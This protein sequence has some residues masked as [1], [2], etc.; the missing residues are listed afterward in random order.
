MEQ[1]RNNKRG[2]IESPPATIRTPKRQNVDRARPAHSKACSR[3][4]KRKI[5]CDYVLPSCSSCKAAGALC[6]G[7]DLALQKEVPRSIV[8]YLE[9]RAAA[10]EIE[11][12]RLEASKLSQCA[13]Q[14]GNQPIANAGN[15]PTPLS[16][17]EALAAAMVTVVTPSGVNDD[18]TRFFHSAF[19]LRPCSLPLP[20]PNQLFRSPS[21]DPVAPS[22]SSRKATHLPDVPRSAADLVLKN[23]VEIHLPQY[24]CVYE[25]DLLRAYELCFDRP[26]EASPFDVFIVCMALAISANTLIWRNEENARAAS[27][28]FWAN[29]M[30]QLHNPTT[31][32]SDIKKL[33]SALL[34][35]HYSFTNPTAVDV[36]YCVGDAARL[37]IQLGYH[38]EV[39]LSSNLNTLELDTRRRLFWTTYGME[40]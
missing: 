15:S 8:S 22:R 3:C 16:I 38:K 40:R 33:Q 31:I 14:N 34:L 18:Y 4:R 26:D 27:A 19:L 17:G 21:L 13:I 32:D 37:C 7:Y 6:V 9:S 25:P 23:Y 10:L 24:P 30:D 1:S 12:R 35:A 2:S 28:G 11:I 5:K 39:S 36:W 20:F 29:A